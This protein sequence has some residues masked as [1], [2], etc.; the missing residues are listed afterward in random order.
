MNFTAIDFET[1]NG[2]RTSACSLG[3]AVVRDLQIVET[4]YWLIRPQPFK[5]NYFNVLVNGLSD[6]QLCDKPLFCDCWEEIR[7]YLENQTIVAH[8]AAF[9][10]SVL[11]R[12]LDYYDLP[13]PDLDYI[14]SYRAS[15][16][17]FRN[18]INYRLDTLAHSL[19]IG[20][21][22]HNALEDARVAAEILIHMIR[23]S[24]CDCI[25]EFAKSIDLKLGKLS[26]SG[27]TS[28]GYIKNLPVSKSRSRSLPLSK[29]IVATTTDFDKDNE[30]YGKTVAFTGALKGMSRAQAY[31]IIANLG[32]YLAD[33]VTKKTDY[34]VLGVQDYRLLNGY[35]LSSKTRKAIKYAKEGTGIQI[36]S[37]KDFYNM[38]GGVCDEE[39][40]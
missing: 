21:N 28:C 18:V 3:I 8:N 6:E 27:H 30:F 16:K 4:K 24:K 13:F 31:Q 33:N 37:E 7:P 17:V 5:F 1:A 32:G 14:C 26:A 25:E 2:N 39:G 15:Q 20:F 11:T 23:S 9:D 19:N 40:Y 12:T 10:I 34:L 22:H 36:I 29:R 38:I 35:K